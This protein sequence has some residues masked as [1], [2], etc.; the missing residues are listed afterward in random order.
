MLIKNEQIR[1]LKVI[2][3]GITVYCGVKVENPI[4]KYHLFAK[5]ASLF[6]RCQ[7]HLLMSQFD[8]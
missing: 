4:V 6:V 7:L 8:S 5:L 1:K 3:I 2:K